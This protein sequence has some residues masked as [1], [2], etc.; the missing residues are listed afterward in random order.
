MV[1]ATIAFGM[2][3]DKSDVRYV[4]HF[5]MPKSIEGYYQEAGRA[6][7][8]GEIATCILYY[9]YK[10]M[11]R[12]KSMINGLYLFNS[13]NFQSIFNEGNNCNFR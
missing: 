4:L 2:G 6:G 10:D 3:I 9:S 5:C 13:R 7:R 12:Y 1:C 11:Q 8:D